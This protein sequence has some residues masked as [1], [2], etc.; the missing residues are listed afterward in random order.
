MNHQLYSSK[1]G[2]TC[3]ICY[4]HWD[5]RP[6]DSFCPGIPMKHNL[7][8]T[9]SAFHCTICNGDWASR[10]DSSCP[11][12]QL[13]HQ[14]IKTD[15]GFH[16]T[17]CNDD[18]EREP[19]RLCRGF[20]IY[21]MGMAP[22]NLKALGWLKKRG[23]HPNGPV[24]GAVLGKFQ[25]Y[26]VYD[27][28]EIPYEYTPRVRKPRPDPM[29]VWDLRALFRQNGIKPKTRRELVDL[30]VPAWALVSWLIFW[31]SPEGGAINSPAEFA[32]RNLRQAPTGAGSMCDL[33]AKLPPGALRRYLNMTPNHLFSLNDPD[34]I[35]CFVR[36]LNSNRL[37]ELMQR[38][39]GDDL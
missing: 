15:A 21:Q 10:P 31:A 36:K 13:Q 14:L 32:I 2:F 29:A 37:P 1:W 33:L 38:L 17:V 25:I 24:R 6:D 23:L 39:F 30:G 27:L 18:W 19:D 11:G 22:K 3:T 34:G 35:G 8:K 4:G 28:N 16:C 7:V 5:S 12:M 20:L 9:K 26:Y